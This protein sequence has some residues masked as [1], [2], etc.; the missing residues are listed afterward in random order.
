M[1]KNMKK[2]IFIIL[3]VII[4]LC[5]ITYGIIVF[6]DYNNVSNGKVPF[7]AKKIDKENFDGIGY[8]I[9][10]KYYNDTEKIETIDIERQVDE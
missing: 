10:V 3:G 1:V 4:I 7:F 9:K 8:N 6:I 5:L 2:K